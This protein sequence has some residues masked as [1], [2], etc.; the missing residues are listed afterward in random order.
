[1]THASRWTARVAGLA[2]SLAGA[3]LGAAPAAAQI[4]DAPAGAAETETPY[5]ANAPA[6][7]ELPPGTAVP[8]A[9]SSIW[10]EVSPEELERLIQKAEATRLHQER[11]NAIRELGDELLYED[12][13]VRKAVALL[14]DTPPKTLSDN[15]RAIVEAL[16]LVDRPFAEARKLYEQGRYRDA[17]AALHALRNPKKTGYLSAAVYHLYA[18]ALHAY[19]R[20][21]A[22]DP[23]Q[24]KLARKMDFK[25]IDARSDLLVHM[26]ERISFAVTSALEAA[27]TYE[28]LDRYQYALEMYVYALK[29]YGLTLDAVRYEAIRKKAEDWAE[30][31]GSPARVLRTVAGHMGDVQQ[32]L[33]AADSGEGTQQT[34]ERIVVL[35]AD[36]IKTL[37]EKAQGGGQ[38]QGKGQGQGQGK[39]Q[40]KGKG[41][42]QGQGQSQGQGKGK[43]KSGPP[44]GTA[45]PSTPAASSALVP[46]AVA[47]PTKLSEARPTEESGAW[48]GLPK[49]RRE[50]IVE[51]MRRGLSD[52]KR[53]QIRDYWT[54]VARESAG[55]AEEELP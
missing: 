10:T 9:N 15:V 24:R 29:N 26:P 52:R 3:A 19:A 48:A 38:G 18:E 31:L 54:A 14:R 25:S 37:E 34:G 7:A 32:R 30:K 50:Q 6:A 35:L 5:D 53:D 45:Q 42:G 28:A 8:D 27:K 1:M 47:R 44:S 13:D 55:G 23:N 22:E 40:G 12:A 4:A 43:G 46:G 49:R 16:A 39:G 11:E 41:K 33:S 21:L 36:L 17:A 51:M 2:L 20:Q